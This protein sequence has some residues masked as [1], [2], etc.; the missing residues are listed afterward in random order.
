MIQKRLFLKNGII[1]VCSALLIRIAGMIFTVFLSGRIGAE[2]LGLYR[3][4]VSVYFFFASAASAGISLTMTRLFGD[5]LSKG[6]SGKAR[7]CARK[8]MVISFMIGAVL[9]G[10]MLASSGFISEH[11]LKDSRT[12]P[13]LLLLAPSLPFMAVSACVR[14][15]FAAR[16]KT[17]Q[18]S[19][20]QL[21]EQVIEMGVFAAAYTLAAPQNIGDACVT[22]VAGTT[23]AEIISFFYSLVCYALDIRKLRCKPEKVSGIGRVILPI[24][25]PVSANSFLRSGLSAIENILIP[26]GL[27]R[28]GS[29]SSMALS[30]Y[31]ILSGMAMP[32]LIFPSVLILPFASLIIPE[33]AEL[34]IGKR[35]KGIRHIAEKM[36]S[37]TVCYS[38]LITAIF[39]FFAQDISELLY[40]NTDAGYFISLL[41][42]VVP[43]MYLD[44]VADGMLKGLNEQTSYFV[45]NL[46]DS[47]IRVILTYLLLP[48]YGIMGMAAVIII[49]ELLNTL[50]SLA[51][52]IQVT[53]LNV[54]VGKNIIRP[55]LCALL[56]CLT[57]SA[58]PRTLPLPADTAIKLLFCCVTY[59]AALYLTQKIPRRK[60]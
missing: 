41:A 15:Y 42:P 3:L 5:Y 45:S 48:E 28:S 46:I 25:L 39:L 6:E 47:V 26:F 43:F 11:L 7:F 58:L 24:A 13:A 53:E 57:V 22:A 1:M 8:C 27:K 36:F 51:R 32:V 4:I 56:P 21:L 54:A 10:V 50:M 18:T 23:A 16:R 37:L 44:S 34:N 12:A 38:I 9:C 29:S 2:G 14:G 20:E 35:K 19:G 17:L 31:G 60:I 33:M 59:C 52:L 30:Q 40:H 55:A 49:S